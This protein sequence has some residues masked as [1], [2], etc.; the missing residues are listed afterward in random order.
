MQR[1]TISIDES[2][3]E[4]F[5]VL[6]AARGYQNRS[7]G[8]R[9]LVRNAVEGWLSEREDA[10]SCV[11]SLSYVFDGGTRALAHRLATLQHDAHDL[12]VCSTQVRIDHDHTLEAVML[13]GD[14]RRVRAF[15][16]HVRA[17]R[18]LRFGALNLISVEPG[19]DHDGDDAHR[20][21]G[22]LHMEP[23]PG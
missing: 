16:D 8:L 5:D 1:I 12:V 3:A 11:A 7:E 2:L 22:A 15:A 18:G 4:T 13:R 9:D 6:I 20:H 14:E 17:E 21:T 23:R 19:D 10:G